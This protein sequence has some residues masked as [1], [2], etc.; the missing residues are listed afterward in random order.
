MTTYRERREARAERLREWADK[1][2]AKAG[3]AFDGARA[4]GDMIPF[5]QP[6]LIGHHS[7]RRH[8][9]DIDRIDTNMRRGVENAR[10]AES[11]RSRADNIEAAAGHAIYSDDPD[12]IERLREKLAELEA[13]REQIK[14]DNKAARSRGDKPQPAYVLQNL[15]GNITRT[16][17]RIAY[18]ER[19]ATTP[20]EQRIS[21]PNKYAGTCEDCGGDVA[22]GAGLLTRGAGRRYEVRHTSGACTKEQSE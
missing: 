3:A 22:A 9:R 11:M 16:R 18:L 20:P 2:E 12:A 4:I 15:G 21:R 6:I 17:Q 10:T 19:L 13:K 8:R 14:T 1:R 7:E 5:G